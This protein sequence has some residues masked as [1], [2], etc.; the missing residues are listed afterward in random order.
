LPFG[1]SIEALEVYLHDAQAIGLER[2]R[3]LLGES[4]GLSISEEAIS[5]MLARAQA[6]LDA[7]AAI[8]AQ[9]RA[10]PVVACDETSMRV[11]GRTCW[12][13]VFV[14]AAGV[15]HLIRPSR[16]AGVVRTLCSCAAASPA[17]VSS[18]LSASP[19]APCRSLLSR[20]TNK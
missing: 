2:L 13:W 14:T 7:A 1:K 8:G 4:F 16:G 10:A 19:T 6:P 3:A 18:C 12:E 15:L 20:S 9:V 11:Q 5:T 17:I